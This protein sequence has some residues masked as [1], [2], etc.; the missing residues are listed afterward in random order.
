M[1]LDR[2]FAGSLKGPDGK[3]AP[4]IILHKPREI[5]A[6]GPDDIVTFLM[7]GFLPDSDYMG[8]AMIEVIK[9]PLAEWPKKICAPLQLSLRRCR[10]IRAL[11]GRTIF[12]DEKYCACGPFGEDGFPVYGVVVNNRQ[13]T[14][15]T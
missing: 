5:W 9:T 1:R 7:D 14:Y 2:E 8:G 6:W 13:V 12:A 11:T 4:N 15:V 3:R 10:N